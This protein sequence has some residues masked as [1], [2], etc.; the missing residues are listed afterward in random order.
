MKL[1]KGADVL[2]LDLLLTCADVRELKVELNLK[3]S[4]PFMLMCSGWL[5][6]GGHLL[7]CRK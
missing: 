4:Y 2:K 3:N 6:G 7:Q 5:L 1:P